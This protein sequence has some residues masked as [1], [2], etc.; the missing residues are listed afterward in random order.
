MS[1]AASAVVI[2]LALFGVF[3]AATW[4]Q[5][6][7]W[8]A[9]WGRSLAYLFLWAG[10]DARP[11]LH[12]ARDPRPVERRDVLAALA[13][14]IVGIAMLRIAVASWHAAPHLVV[15]ATGIA[16][17]ALLLHFGVLRLADLAWRAAGV[18]CR[19]LMC[20]PVAATSLADFWARRWNTSFATLSAEL[21]YRPL[22]ARLGAGAARVVT[23]L[24]SGLIHELA[25]TVPARAGFGGPT[26]FF[27]LQGLAVGFE[28]SRHGRA[29]GL[30]R[31]LRGRAFTLGTL[32]LPTPLLF[33]PAF[34]DHIVLPLASLLTGWHIP[35]ESPMPSVLNLA[36]WL[37]GV[38]HFCVLA[39]GVQVPHRL[40]WKAELPRLSRFNQRLVWAYHV[41][42]G[43][44]IL[45]F[46]TLT[47][48]LHDEI[49]RGERAALGLVAFMAAWWLLR[50]VIDALWYSHEDWPKGRRFVVGHALLVFAFVGMAGTYVAVLIAHGMPWTGR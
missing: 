4:W 30:G 14:I 25:I 7:G 42:I 29:L 17:F 19:P 41:F 8:R 3:K 45:A 28:R 50:L 18:D 47:L 33:P 27:L 12:G 26:A 6:A 24:G 46:G 44:T 21:A 43:L 20:A 10:M 16:G 49:M 22:R 37:A 36:L 5:V 2:A 31:G 38:A 13:S 35:L 34:V 15:A 1:P 39:A 48:A 40:G 11:F 23:F 9:P 32:L